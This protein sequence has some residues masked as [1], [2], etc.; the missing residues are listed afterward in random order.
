MV[1]WGITTG[2]NHRWFCAFISRS[3][4]F[5]AEGQALYGSIL[6]FKRVSSQSYSCSYYTPPFFIR[7]W[8]CC[9][10]FIYISET[11]DNFTYLLSYLTPQ[12]GFQRSIKPI[13]AVKSDSP[14]FNSLWK[15]RACSC[16]RGSV[17]GPVF[18]HCCENHINKTSLNLLSFTYFYCLPFFAVF[19]WSFN[20]TPLPNFVSF[21]LLVTNATF[22]WR[23]LHSFTLSS[24]YKV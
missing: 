10:N 24:F 7:A 2:K 11:D 8:G 4:I 9:L 1:T 3:W 19:I 5:F 17:V 12:E 23:C 20:R 16:R 14:S 15:I 18:S 21:P 6:K 13:L 22:F